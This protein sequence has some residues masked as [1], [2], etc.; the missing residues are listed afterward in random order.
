MNSIGIS[1]GSIVYTQITC[2]CEWVCLP[3]YPPKYKLEK[4]CEYCKQNDNMIFEAPSEFGSTWQ[5]RPITKLEASHL[6]D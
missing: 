6:E 3:T 5:F 2:E 4:K 1:E